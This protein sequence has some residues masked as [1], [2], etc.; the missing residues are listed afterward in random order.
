MPAP[1]FP[2]SEFKAATRANPSFV[3]ITADDVA[4]PAQLRA[5]QVCEG[6]EKPFIRCFGDGYPIA[7]GGD[8]EG[9]VPVVI[10]SC[11]A[12]W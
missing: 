3:P 7:R 10:E 2:A 4:V 9:L 11:R 1:P 12:A 6:W 8:A 5:W